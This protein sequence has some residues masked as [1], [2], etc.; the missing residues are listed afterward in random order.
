[1]GREIDRGLA[2]AALSPEAVHDL[3]R[4]LRRLAILL[5]VW[6][7]LV[8]AERAVTVDELARR[9]RRLARLVGRVRDRD[10]TAGLLEPSARGRDPRW[11]EF[12]GRLREDREAGRELLRAF[13]TSERQA[14]LLD[15]L[16]ET[17]AVEP[18]AGAARSLERILTDIRH[19]RQARV[20]KAHR[21]ARRDPSAERLHRLRIR[22]R[23]WRHLAALESV[24]GSR[25]NPVTSGW[26]QLQGRLG[27]L[28]DLDVA[29][30]TI[31]EE[32]GSAPVALRLTERRRRVR[33]EVRRSLERMGPLPRAAATPPPR[34]GRG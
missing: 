7:R 26:Q 19:R 3:H 14:G 8:P 2:P 1:V 33:L 34:R 12:L 13:L 25:R 4:D 17:L 15:R 24:V 32:L 31:P 30:A 18:R 11:G 27:R 22:I 9:L 6:E 10:V 20:D 16:A 28:H 23:Q 29:L 21:K 5:S